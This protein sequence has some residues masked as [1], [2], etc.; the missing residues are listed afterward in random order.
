MTRN[1]WLVTI[2][3][4]IVVS[5]L[6]VACVA[7][8]AL[9][10]LADRGA[11][12][13]ASG[14]AAEPTAQVTTEVREEAEPPSS[15]EES[16]PAQ[17]QESSPTEPPASSESAESQERR[18]GG[19]LT[20]VGADP[21]TL[22]PHLVT[23][24][25][26]A[27]YIVEIFSGLVSLDPDLQIVP[28]LAKDWDIDESGTVYTFHLRE[29]AQFHDGKP[30]T[31]QHF[32]WSFER[33]LDP[34][35][36]STVSSLYLNDI[37]GA[38]DKL[39]GE[40]DEVTGV[41]VID[42]HTLQITIDAPKAY[43]LAKLTYPTGFVLDQENVESGGDTWTDQP[44]GAGAYRL[45]EYRLGEEI[46]L[47]RNPFYYGEPKPALQRVRFLLA[48]GSAMIMY[49]SGDIDATPV[50]LADIERVLD[51]TDPL[52]DELTVVAP[53]LSTFYVGLDNDIP[54][55]DDP[56]IRQALNYAIDKDVLANVVLRQTI[57]PAEGVLPPKMPGYNPELDVYD[58]D[59][60]RAKELI[61]ASSYGSVEDLPDITLT[62]SGGGAEPGIVA[63]AVL[64]MLDQNLGLEV[65]VELVESAIFFSEVGE[66][67]Y[68]MFV[69]G[70][71][72]DYP[73]P[74][75][76]LD[77]MF[78]TASSNNHINYSNPEVDGL[79]EEARVEQDHEQRMALYQEVERIIIE[80][81]PWIPLFHSAEYWLT[82]PYVKGMIYPPAVVPRLKYVWL[83]Q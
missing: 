56:K 2:G 22:D 81:A 50:G 44:N 54:P 59:I 43:F 31:A 4:V 67:S 49:E 3:A 80:D 45:R 14:P 41:Q 64:G 52:N 82:K 13:P 16:P 66:G 60:E 38:M 72:A 73:D 21:A 8:L 48:G 63:T 17:Q 75:D 51:P 1:Q 28:D 65:S 33:A 40:A 26:S 32:K 62:T 25:D 71:S 55:F 23:D 10:M 9:G 36:G 19:T 76:F 79:L 11:S 5:L 35:T 53:T 77:I 69:L 27:T 15:Q 30:V 6:A 83:A 42:D 74:Q 58:F 18:E 24:F 61:A 37:V 78:H 20:L 68:Q 7:V 57:V 70:W 34:A 39:E 47:E 29:E 12:T 46:V